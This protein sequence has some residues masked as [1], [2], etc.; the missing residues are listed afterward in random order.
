MNRRVLL[1]RLCYWFGAIVDAVAVIP[2]LFPS[3]AARVFGIDNFHP[4]VEYRYAMFLAASLML[5]WTALLLWADRRPVERAA[6]L[7]LTVCPVVLGLAAAGVFAVREGLIPA[8]R[9]L[10]TWI[11]QA[12]LAAG[13]TYAYRSRPTKDARRNDVA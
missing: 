10:P 5:G 12:A 8:G 9:M 1:L 13:L 3:A 2:M 4:G 7:A 6:V 11:A